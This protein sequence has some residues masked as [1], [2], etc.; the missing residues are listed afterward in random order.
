MNGVE[1]Y[2]LGQ[3]LLQIAHEALPDDSPMRGL[4][5]AARM[6]LADVTRHSGAARQEIATRTGLSA[7]QASALV[8]ELADAGL[9]RPGTDSGGQQRVIVNPAQSFRDAPRS[10]VD[11]ALATVL[12]PAGAGQVQQ[13]IASLEALARQLGTSS[14]IPRREG[15]DAAYTGTPA[16]E[17]GRPQPAI[18]ELAA[19]GAFRGRV[20]DVGCGTGEHALLAASLGLPAVGVDTSPRAIAIAERKAADRGLMAKFGVHDALDLGTFGLGGGLDLDGRGDRFETVI[21]SGLFHIFS[22]E[23]RARYAASLCQV[24]PPGGRL[25]LLCFS[26]RQP[27]GFGP[28]RVTQDEIRATFAGDWHVEAIDLVTMDVTIRPEG[29]Q[30]W[31]ATLTRV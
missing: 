10:P 11:A 29:I 16:W 13:A 2:L 20:L 4:S 9:L 1:L 18:A 6:V 26:D 27:A 30:A 12:G 31:L 14:G 7:E 15:F 8:A 24:V 21:D 5:P 22:D 25:F 3:Q 28:R 19:S 17:I 23:D